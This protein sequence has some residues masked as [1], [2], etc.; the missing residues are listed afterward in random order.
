MPEKGRFPEMQIRRERRVWRCPR[1]GQLM[2][3]GRQGLH[4][5]MGC[6]LERG[7]NPGFSVVIG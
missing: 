5:L 1:C 2:P 4:V 3:A 6:T 7:E